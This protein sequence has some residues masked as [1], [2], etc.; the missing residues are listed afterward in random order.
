[1]PVIRDHPY[2]WVYLSL[3]VFGSHVNVDAANENFTKLKI[4]VVKEEVDTSQTCQ[5]YDQLQEKM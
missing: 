2:W 5:A 1:M 4:W 3:Y